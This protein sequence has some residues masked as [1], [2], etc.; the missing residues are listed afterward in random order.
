MTWKLPKSVI[1]LS[2]F[3][4]FVG[5]IILF[6]EVIGGNKYTGTESMIGKTVIITGT[7]TG[8]GRETALEM[9]KRRAR[10]IMACRDL[11]K[12]KEASAPSRIINVSSVA[13]KRGKINFDD[14]NSEKTYDEGDAYAQSKLANILFTR[15]LAERLEDVDMK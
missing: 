7:N 12:C 13:H 9:A 10:V 6:K 4:S 8:I 11:E 15:E 2:A 1:G 5:G 14:L 3:G